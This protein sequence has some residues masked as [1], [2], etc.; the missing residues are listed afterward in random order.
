MA[1]PIRRWNPFRE[2]EHFRRDFDD[3]FD[4]FLGRGKRGEK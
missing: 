4:R 2:M 1:N 3:L